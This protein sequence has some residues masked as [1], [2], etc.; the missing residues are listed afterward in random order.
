MLKQLVDEPTRGPNSLDLAL[1][2]LH[3]AAAT[4]VIPGIAEYNSIRVIVKLQIPKVHAIQRTIKHYRKA[5]WKGL[6]DALQE[7]NYEISSCAALD[8]ATA[9]FVKQGA[10]EAKRYIPTRTLRKRNGAH[11]WLHDGCRNAVLYKQSRAGIKE[12]QDACEAC[13]LVLRQTHDEYIMK[14]REELRRVS[15]ESKHW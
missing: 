5:D 4:T 10:S 12:Y 1:S 15:K 14:M 9:S 11:P 6:H 13:T 2:S 3:A 8:V 7:L